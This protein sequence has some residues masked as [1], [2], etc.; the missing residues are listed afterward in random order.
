MDEVHAFESAVAER[1]V[2]I[3]RDD[4]DN[5]A[6]NTCVDVWQYLAENIDEF[7]VAK[8]IVDHFDDHPRDLQGNDVDTLGLYLRAKVTI[9]REQIAYAQAQQAVERVRL[10]SRGLR[11]VLKSA[12]GVAV[13]LRGAVRTHPEAV[14]MVSVLLLWLV[15]R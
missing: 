13:N 6:D 2:A 12:S 15:A 14:L 5:A 4:F 7:A 1:I 11:G 3:G 10:Q 9:K 8:S